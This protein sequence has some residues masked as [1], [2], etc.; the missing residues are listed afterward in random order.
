MQISLS[1]RATRFGN[2]GVGFDA[3]T[4]S[5]V[6]IVN[7]PPSEVDKRRNLQPF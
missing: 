5:A 3:G 7:F 2:G 6:E 1:V 4:S